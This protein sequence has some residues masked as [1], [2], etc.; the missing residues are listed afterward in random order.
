VLTSKEDN[1]GEFQERD[2]GNWFSYRKTTDPWALKH[3]LT[4]EIDVLD[5]VRFAHVFKTRAHIC[6]DE[7]DGIPVVETWH[8]RRHSPYK[9]VVDF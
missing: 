6:L 5:G 3:G 9:D 7:L 8:F 1:C 4:Y 2:R